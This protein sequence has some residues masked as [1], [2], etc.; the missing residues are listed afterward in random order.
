MNGVT[1]VLNVF[2]AAARR[3][4]AWASSWD[5]AKERP[6]APSAIPKMA[7]AIRPLRGTLEN[8]MLCSCL[9]KGGHHGVRNNRQS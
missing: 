8:V 2:I 3:A 6:S 7:T 1:S 5:A 4:S 9:R